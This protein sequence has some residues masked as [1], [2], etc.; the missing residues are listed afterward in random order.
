MEEEPK[1][2]RR[3]ANRHS[4]IK[5]GRTIG[6][7]REKIETA[8]ERMAARQKDKRKKRARIFIVSLGFIVIAAIL[9]ILYFAFLENKDEQFFRT[10]TT[11][12]Y[13]PTVEIIVEDATAGEDNITSR[14]REYI[15]QVESDF[16]DLG[17][18][19]TKAVVP[20][21]SIRE[22][23]FYLENQPGFIKMIIDRGSAMSVEDADRMIRYLNGQGI[24]EFRYI[25]VRV[26]GKAYWQ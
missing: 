1:L 2:V 25:D 4:T 19:L 7:R 16:H 10:D 5:S 20:T 11:E 13:E 14:M 21:N 3:R 24:T 17:Y 9:V 22:V 8:N 6:E 12:T 15:G 23:D 18:H 26:S